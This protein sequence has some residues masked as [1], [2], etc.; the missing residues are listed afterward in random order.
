MLMWLQRNSNSQPLSLLMKPFSQTSSKKV[1]EL[2]CEYLFVL[3]IWLYVLVISCTRFKGTLCSKQEQYLKFKWL[4]LDSDH[5]QLV[6]KQT[7]KHVS[8]LVLIWKIKP[9]YQL[10]YSFQSESTHYGGPNFKELL[11]ETGAI[12]EVS[13]IVTGLET[14]TTL[15]VN[16]HSISYPKWFLLKILGCVVSTYLYNAFDWVFL[17]CH[18]RVPE[19]NRTI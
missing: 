2:C 13:V 1:I 17:S 19:W 5:N 3:L 8:N 6:C 7:L 9:S 11:L 10:S 4:Q 16:K 12:F 14:K 15:F 18:V